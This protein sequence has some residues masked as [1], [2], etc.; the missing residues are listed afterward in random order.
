MNDIPLYATLTVLIGIVSLIITS[1]KSQY[2]KYTIIIILC[3]I[4]FVVIKEIHQIDFG[5]SDNKN[6]ATY[7]NE[8][9]PVSNGKSF[10]IDRTISNK[11]TLQ[12]R[13]II[14]NS[15]KKSIIYDIGV[16]NIETKLWKTHGWYRI[17]PGKESVF[18]LPRSSQGRI[19]GKVYLY[20]K[21]V[22][23][24]NIWWGGKYQFVTSSDAHEIYQ[25]ND[26]EPKRKSEY[27]LS[28]YGEIDLKGDRIV[29]VI[30]K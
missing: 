29:K 3:V 4:A 22:D 20:A 7:I 27:M 21:D 16:Y 11:D 10:A 8:P 9:A 19:N 25:K 14:A 2:L 24:S 28:R 18:K 30:I 13:L 23:D 15:H 1:I 17:E 12:D 5:F 26:A 6:N